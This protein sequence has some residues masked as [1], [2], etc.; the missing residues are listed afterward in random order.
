MLTG[1]LYELLE[2][3]EEFTHTGSHCLYNAR[4]G[5]LLEDKFNTVRLKRSI[6]V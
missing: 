5:I 6:Y 2:I 4:R 3:T 1:E